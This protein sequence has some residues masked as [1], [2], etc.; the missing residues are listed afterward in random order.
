MR[1]SGAVALPIETTTIGWT[2]TDFIGPRQKAARRAP[3][4]STLVEAVKPCIV[5]PKVKSREHFLCV[6]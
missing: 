2:R 6:A 1:C 4:S 5:N 3:C